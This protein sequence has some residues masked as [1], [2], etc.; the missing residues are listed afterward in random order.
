MGVPPS[1]AAELATEADAY[2]YLEGLRWSA[3]PACPHCGS[4]RAPYYLTPRDGRSRQTRTGASTQR[5]VWKCASCR[6]Q[7]SVLTGTVLEGTRIPVRTWVA[8]V[9]DLCASADGLAAPEIERAH[10]VTAKTARRMLWRI[11]RATAREHRRREPAHGDARI[12]RGRRLSLAGLDAREALRALLVARPGRGA[13]PSS[14]L[15]ARARGR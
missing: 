14:P 1:R 15:A 9:V 8:V 4:P 12:A 6:R 3:G 5:R 7:L 10:G 11:D 2:A 13:S